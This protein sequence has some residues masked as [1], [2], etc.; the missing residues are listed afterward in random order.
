MSTRIKVTADSTCD[1]SPALLAAYDVTLASLYVN[2]GEKTYRDGVD[3]QPDDVFEAFEKDALLAKTAAVSIEDYSELF[4]RYTQRG[5][6]VIHINISS[7]FSS[8]YQN[9][10]LAAKE[11][12]NVYVVDSRN[13]SSGSGHLVLM[14]VE[15]ARK[16][17]SAQEI[18]Q[19]LEIAKSKVEASFVI[20]TLTYLYKGGRCSALA[21]L[22]ANMFRLKPCIEVRD[23]KM[24]VGK[25]YRGSVKKAILHYVE[26]RLEDRRDLDTSRIF[27]THTGC[28]EEIV[29][30]VRQKI[31]ALQPFTEILETRAGCTVSSHCGPNTLG[32]LFLRK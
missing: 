24:D 26:D 25:K 22:G 3:I 5:D 21:A 23:G 32:I 31:I 8:S 28:C 20:N 18:V 9:A 27:I 14:A 15:L 4:T 6:S 17:L 10:C 11:M 12:D 16:G 7:E 13:L 19:R 30:A 1:L 29:E 2:I